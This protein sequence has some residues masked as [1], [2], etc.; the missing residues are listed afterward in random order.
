MK[1][2]EWIYE[3]CHVPVTLDHRE[4]CPNDKDRPVDAEALLDWLQAKR[5]LLSVTGYEWAWDVSGRG[6]IQLFMP[7]DLQP[8]HHT[9]IRAALR[10]AME[11]DRV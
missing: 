8:A 6:D 3:C 1:T 9:D 2:V 11:R 10:A 4:G 5:D 7:D